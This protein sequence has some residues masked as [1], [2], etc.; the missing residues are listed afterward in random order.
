M[1][2]DRRLLKKLHQGDQNALRSIYEKHKDDLITVA[3]CL[4]GDVAAAEDC[5]H[6]VFVFFAANP[7]AINIRSSLKGYLIAS[8]ANRARDQLRKRSRQPVLIAEVPDPVGR[9]AEPGVQMMDCEETNRA[10]AALAELPFEQREVITLHLQGEMTFKEISE[11]QDVS[12]NTLQSR[13][14]YGLDKLR[15]LLNTG[16]QK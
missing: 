10:V 13:Y 9:D 5:L 3:R 15:T 1:L 11:L 12:I 6:D 14:R 2:E 8:I 16:A 4:L 7:S